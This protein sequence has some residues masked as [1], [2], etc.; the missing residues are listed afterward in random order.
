MSD[1]IATE[2]TAPDEDVLR[3]LRE[4][5]ERVKELEQ[6]PSPAVFPIPYVVPYPYPS[7]PPS[8]PEITWTCS[9]SGGDS[10]GN[11]R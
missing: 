11:S 2:A 10:D 8:Y 1:S 7:P 6:R 3:L 9:C 5:L 4:L